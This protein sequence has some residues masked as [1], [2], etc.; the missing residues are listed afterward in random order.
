[1][2][3]LR[4]TSDMFGRRML[5]GVNWDLI[6]V[7]VAAAAAIIVLHLILRRVRRRRH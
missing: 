2:E 5:V 7:P 6:W 1:M 3:W 4:Y